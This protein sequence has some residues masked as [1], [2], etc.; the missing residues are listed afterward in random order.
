MSFIKQKASFRDYCVIKYVTV[1]KFIEF[2]KSE[3]KLLEENGECSVKEKERKTRETKVRKVRKR[4]KR[5][6][7]WKRGIPKFSYFRET[8]IYEVQPLSLS[9]PTNLYLHL[10]FSY[11]FCLF[12]HILRSLAWRL[13]TIHT[14]T[15]AQTLS[16]KLKAS[17]HSRRKRD[18]RRSKD[19]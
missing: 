15:S 12:S 4:S 13:L 10:F 16:N 8:K 17:S 6:Y 9:I 18:R 1:T 2:V 3:K 5:R 19:Q 14:R 11:Y 7:R